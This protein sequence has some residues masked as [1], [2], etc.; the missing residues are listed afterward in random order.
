MLENVSINT[1]QF[2]TKALA[3]LNIDEARVLLLKEISLFMDNQIKENKWIN[4]NF[5]C[6]HNS[7]RSQLAQVWSNYASNYYNFKKIESF[8]GGTAVTAFLEIR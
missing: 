7:R 2:F 5:I 8:S 6:T 1:E 4:L 3:D